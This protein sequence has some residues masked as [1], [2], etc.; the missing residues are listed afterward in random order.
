MSEV[1]IPD[2]PPEP[3][4]YLDFL[5][6]EWG[7]FR[8]RWR[9]DSLLKP[10]W[11]E[12]FLARWHLEADHLP[13]SSELDALVELRTLMRR[14]GASLHTGE[15]LNDDLEKLNQVFLAAAVIRHIQW[16]EGTFLLE[17]KPLEK[18]WHSVMADIAASFAEFLA[19]GDLQR[20][21][22]CENPY[23]RGFFY[24]ETKSR[25]KHWCTNSKCGNLW[26]VRRFRARQKK[27][28]IDEVARE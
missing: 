6:S 28:T 15:P 19:F 7:D 12:K 24:D 23:C 22:I 14:I 10:E 11:L 4:L 20:L 21:K 9:V 18:N 1:T 2:L 8:G 26:K 17:I 5:N 16:N 25:T 13:T 27:R 3:T